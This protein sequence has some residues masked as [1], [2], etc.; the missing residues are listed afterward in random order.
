MSNEGQLIAL[1]IIFL[2]IFG[3][4]MGIIQWVFRINKIVSELEQI[5]KI[6]EDNNPLSRFSKI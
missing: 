4:A 6:L 5:R 2:G 1:S 3:I